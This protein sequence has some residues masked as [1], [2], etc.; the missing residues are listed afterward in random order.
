MS[1]KR[2]EH[3]LPPF[4]EE[5]VVVR[6]NLDLADVT[7]AWREQDET[8]WFWRTRDGENAGEKYFT[9]WKALPNV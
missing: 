7:V 8:S 5:V 9:H 2:T 3:H 4:G 1:W 6:A